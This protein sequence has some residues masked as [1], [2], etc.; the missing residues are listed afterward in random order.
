MWWNLM[1][2]QASFKEKLKYTSQ[3]WAPSVPGRAKGKIG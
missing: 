1:S 3:F 2:F